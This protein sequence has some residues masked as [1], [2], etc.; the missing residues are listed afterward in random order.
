M[1]IAHLFG[2]SL[3]TPSILSLVLVYWHT[4]PVE[5]YKINT[6][7]Y[8]KDEFASGWRIIWDSSVSFLLRGLYS[9]IYG[10][11][12]ILLWPFTASSEVGD[13]GLF[14]P[15]FAT[16]DISLPSTVILFL[17][18]IAKAIKWLTYL[19]QRVEIVVAILSTASR[20]YRNITAA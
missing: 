17:I 5:S 11:S 3:T 14:R 13:L 18:F 9:Q 20:T 19:L 8:V 10:L 7:G 2:I 12:P 16:S 4:P 6:D 1:D 15:L